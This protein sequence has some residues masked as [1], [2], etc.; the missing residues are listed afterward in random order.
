MTKQ[1]YFVPTPHGTGLIQEQHEWLANDLASVD[2]TLHPWVVIGLH[3]VCLSCVKFVWSLCA[4]EVC[5]CE[6]CVSCCC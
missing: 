2:R 6:V 3:Q 4:C 1:A 5:V